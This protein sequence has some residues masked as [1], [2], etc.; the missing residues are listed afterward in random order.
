MQK[1][2]DTQQL[3][4]P[5]D[6]IDCWDRYPRH[7]W[8]YDLSR[9]LDAQNIRWSPF[10]VIGMSREVNMTLESNTPVETHSADIYVRRSQGQQML[11][12][13]Y[14]VRGEVRHMRHI[15]PE[16][17]EIITAL[18]GEIELRLNAFITLHFVKFTGVITARTYG[19]EIHG[20]RLKPQSDLGQED[21]IE[22]IKLVK[23]I[24]KRTD[25]TSSGLT[26]QTLHVSLAS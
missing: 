15:N 9:L 6:D 10:P 8:V 5:A 12:E 2:F 1:K 4:I 17:G 24:Y 26:D 11:T 19:N 20:I 13:V 21:N 25:S 14:I 16:S 22:I 3:D 7:R 18:V 23:R